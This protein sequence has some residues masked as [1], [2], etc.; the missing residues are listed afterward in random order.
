LSVLDTIG[1]WSYHGDHQPNAV[2]WALRS[3]SR[4]APHS[5]FSPLDIELTTP[6]HLL[7]STSTGDVQ[8]VIQVANKYRIP[9]TPY[10]GGTSLEGHFSSPFGGISL[11][12]SRMDKILKINGKYSSRSILLVMSLSGMIRADWFLRFPSPVSP[13]R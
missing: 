11:D 4:L 12:L 10:S 9:V 2:I 3:V 7:Q 8:R 6:S 1:E 5:A 13:F